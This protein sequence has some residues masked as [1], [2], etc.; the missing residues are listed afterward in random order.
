MGLLLFRIFLLIPAL[1]LISCATKSVDFDVD[2]SIDDDPVQETDL[3]LPK[4]LPRKVSPTV[5]KSSSRNLRQTIHSTVQSMDKVPLEYNVHVKKWVSYFKGR[6][7]RHMLKYLQRSTRYIPV[8]QAILKEHGLPKELVYLALIESGFSWKAK[9][10]MSA[11]GFWQFIRG[12]GK[13]YGLKINKFVDERRDPILS[14]HAAAKYL[15][16]LY[17]LFGS[18][19]LAIAS[20]NVGEN[21]MKRVVMRYQTRD[22]WELVRLKA[23]PAETLNY[24][25]KFTAA[26]I[27]AANPAAYGFNDLQNQPRLRFQ[28]LTIFRPVSISALSGQLG[29]TSDVM[30]E[31]NPAFRSGVI[32]VE[33]RK[34][35]VIRVPYGMQR[36]ASAVIAK[37]YIRRNRG[38]NQQYVYYKVKSGENLFQI[39]RRFSTSV[40]V[41]TD[42]NA[43]QRKSV[44]RQ[45]K[46]LKVPSSRLP[47]QALQ[48]PRRSHKSRKRH[49]VRGGETLLG[50]AQRYGISLSSLRTRNKIRPRAVLM[51]GSWLKIP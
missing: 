34:S 51:A 46:I 6:G 9:S 18:W 20:Y 16:S 48:A 2:Q 21:K 37:A 49:K 32:P 33:H 38:S 25:P 43:I 10:S 40:G 5:F 50:I 23:L 28:E 42:L 36:T 29:V 1:F 14:T 39:A 11:V 27:I 31:L 8:M 44:L 30:S 19:Y 15:K 17:N 35:Q 45:G 47:R 26:R 22:Y 7:R 41:L 3:T 4:L 24:V 13:S 12:T